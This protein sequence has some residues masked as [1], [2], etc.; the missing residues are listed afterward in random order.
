MTPSKKGGKAKKAGGRQSVSAR[1][2]L[3]FPAGRVGSMLR[4]GRYARRVSAS[5]AVYTTAVLEYLTSELLEL[6]VKALNAAKK[7]HR[8]T[9]R[10]ITL[11][12]RLDE[13]LGNLL[14]NVTISRG[15]VVPNLH[16]A[17]QKKSKAAAG[18]KKA[19]KKSS[20]TPKL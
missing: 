16:K 14:H 4:R 13:D 15:G 20:A 12:V 18:G 3:V 2:G 9:P 8:L 19:G 1:A 11:A 5:A 10:A 6:S 17:L 7:G